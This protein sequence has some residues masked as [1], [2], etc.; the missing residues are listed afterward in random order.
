MRRETGSRTKPL[1]RDRILEAAIARFSR[2]SYEATGLRDIAAD[3]GVDVAYVHRCFGSK[4]RLFAAA[5]QAAIKPERF[6]AGPG[7]DLAATLSQQALANQASQGPDQTGPLD[8]VI[9]SL[10]SPEASRVLRAV[11]LKDFIEPIAGR[12]GSP[13]A[14]RAALIAALLAGVGILRSVL[15][16][17]AL[18]EAEGGELQTLIRTAIDSM[19]DAET[20][21]QCDATRAG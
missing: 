20:A 16:V 3:V 13:A 10:S 5:V 12:L 15:G 4:E 6:L 14:S 1:T 8:I 17:A 19:I 7:D 11:M 21:S 2:H 9:H 18:Q